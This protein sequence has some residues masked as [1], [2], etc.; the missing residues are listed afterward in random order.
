[1][2]TK[3]AF[4][5]LFVFVSGSALGKEKMPISPHAN[6]QVKTGVIKGALLK[7]GK[8]PLPGAT[9]VLEIVQGGNLILTIPKRTDPKGA[10]QFKNIFMSPEFSYAISSEFEG[11][12]YST[13][14]VSLTEKEIEKRL[15]LI[16]GEGGQESPPLE[17]SP[18]N[19]TDA[20]A[21]KGFNE[22]Q[23]LAIILS[24]GAI[25]YAFLRRKKK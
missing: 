24:I 14:F 1:M 4:L 2:K 7:D 5:I 8:N 13:D 19:K 6:N 16:V 9:V 21:K 23:L 10:F 3:L 20:P 12:R 11:K 17:E 25:A 15:D 22:Y 18:M